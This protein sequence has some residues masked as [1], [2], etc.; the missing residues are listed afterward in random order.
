ML[1]A[2]MLEAAHSFVE[3]LAQ[4]MGQEGATDIGYLPTTVYAPFHAQLDRYF[5]LPLFFLKSSLG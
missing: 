3:G 1:L 5:A 4:T 2:S